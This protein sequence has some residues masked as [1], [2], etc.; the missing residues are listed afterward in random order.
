MTQL[1]I[2]IAA[3]EIGKLGPITV[4]NSLLTSWIV[5]GI[6][7]FLFI[8]LSSSVREIPSVKQ[9]FIELPV[10]MIYLLC[11]SIAGRKAGVFFPYIA[12]FFLFILVANWSGLVPGVGAILVAG[13]EGKV[14]L[15]RA[16]TADLNLTFALAL[17]SVGLIQ[18]QGIKSLGIKY[19]GKFFSLNP[20]KAFIGFLELISELAKVLSFSFRLFGNIFAGEVLLVV[21]AVLVPILAPI[22]FYG[23]ELFVGFIQ[24]L[25]FSMLTLVFFNMAAIGHEEED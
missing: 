7:V 8:K 9:L 2:S 15:L 21:I 14:P 12:V 11:R 1:H 3:E 4:T 17:V 10:E 22:P 18:Y 19:F 20:T 25:V 5:V 13:Q 6:L 16:P 24:A 23:L